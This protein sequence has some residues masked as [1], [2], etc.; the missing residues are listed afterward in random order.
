MV[1]S[2]A[3]T[4]FVAFS[5]SAMCATLRPPT[6]HINA[7]HCHRWIPRIHSLV[8]DRHQS[9]IGEHP[10]STSRHVPAMDGQAAPESGCR[11]RTSAETHFARVFLRFIR[12]LNALLHKFRSCVAKGVHT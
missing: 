5:G 10:E 7:G 6:A 9:V 11:R 12:I 2:R 3:D 8:V 1:D 4:Y